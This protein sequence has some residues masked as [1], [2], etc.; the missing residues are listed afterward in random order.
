MNI[1]LFLKLFFLTVIVQ[2]TVTSAFANIGDYFLFDSKGN[3]HSNLLVLLNNF[4]YKDI[5]LNST[6][7]SDA[8]VYGQTQGLSVGLRRHQIYMFSLVYRQNVEN[9]RK[10]T[11]IAFRSYL[12]GFY[13]IGD[14]IQNLVI[15]FSKRRFHTYYEA[16]VAITSIVDP[17]TQISS[18]YFENALRIG[19]EITLISGIFLDG[20]IG[21]ATYKS[22]NTWV[23]G[24]GLGVRF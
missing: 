3:K 19:L 23:T 10:T 12:P 21:I 16:E 15:D 22:N 11:G 1:N 17:T 8:F 24:A 18:K 4:T 20:S 5:N 6:P 7:E 9:S 2:L 14:S 13:L